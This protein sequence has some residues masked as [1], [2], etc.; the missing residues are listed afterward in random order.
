MIDQSRHV[1]LRP[2]PWASNEVSAAVMKSSAMR[3]HNLIQNGFGL[4]R[5][6]PSTAVADIVECREARKQLGRGRYSLWTGDTGLAI[7]LWDCLNALP[8]F[9]TVDVF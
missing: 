4:R 7:Y 6:S 3:L 2:A 8:R 1:A 9:P 5:L